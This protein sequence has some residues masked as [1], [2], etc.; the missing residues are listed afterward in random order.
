MELN[1]RQREA[2][3]HA[4][5]PLLIVAGAGTGKTRV[6]VEKVGYLLRNVPGLAPEHILAL[7]FSDKAANE[8]KE[9]A[10]KQFGEEG[11]GCRFST[12]HAFCYQ[13][14]SEHSPRTPP[15][16]PLDE[17][18]HWIFLRR[19]LE[20]L[21]LDHYLHV[22][23]PGRFLHDLLQFCS[24]CHD[25]LVTPASFSAFVDQLPATS[26]A[27]ARTKRRNP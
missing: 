3:E 26:A 17:I 15:W 14:L 7:T 19:K 22:S 18:D 27:P 25:N 12:F 9:R 10:A 1:E 6:I 13:L 5:G 4:E 8:M 21:E 24:R 11:R 16:K 20:S 23:E 2:V